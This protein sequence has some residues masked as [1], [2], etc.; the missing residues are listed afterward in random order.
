[1]S[2][3]VSVGNRQNKCYIIDNIMCF[4]STEETQKSEDIAIS[5]QFKESVI[6]PILKVTNLPYYVLMRVFRT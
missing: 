3:T 4:F 5:K 6:Q 2:A 1:M